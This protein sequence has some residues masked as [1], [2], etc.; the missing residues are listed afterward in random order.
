VCVR[1]KTGE[2]KIGEKRLFE[3]KMRTK[4]SNQVL[5]VVGEILSE[6]EI[7]RLKTKL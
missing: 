6:V 4:D 1:F 7:R 3:K 5:Q 2:V